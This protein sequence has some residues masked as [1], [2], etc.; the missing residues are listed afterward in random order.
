MN[1]IENNRGTAATLM[2]TKETDVILYSP[3]IEC[4]GCARSIQ[5]AVGGIS[6]VKT[7]DV[8]V[9]AKTVRVVSETTVVTSAIVAAMDKAGF[10]VEPLA[11]R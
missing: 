3:D 7:V 2:G 6:G 11:E 5:T 4:D 1:V 10:S 8:D 9:A